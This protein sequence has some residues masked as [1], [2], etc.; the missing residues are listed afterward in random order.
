MPKPKPDYAYEFLSRTLAGTKP[1]AE[2]IELL[3]SER[4]PEDLHLDYKSGKEF[5]E[6]KTPATPGNPTTYRGKVQRFVAG[7]AN[8]DGGLL[9]IGVG[10]VKK[11]NAHTGKEEVHLHVDG[12][13]L[14]TERAVLLT[15]EAVI[16]LRPYL[17]SH[18]IIHPVDVGGE[19][20]LVVAVQRSDSLVICLEVNKSIVHYLRIHDSTPSAPGYLVEDIVLGR[21]RRP[22]FRVTH[23]G[24][25]AEQDSQ[26]KEWRTVNV[27]I[28]ATNEGLVWMHEPCAGIVTPMRTSGSVMISDRLLDHI[29]VIPPFPLTK[30][31]E[32]QHLPLTA[33][34][35]EA[36]SVGPFGK[37]G[38]SYRS[39]L[40]K[41]PTMGVESCWR[42]AV[43]VVCRDQPPSWHQLQIRWGAGQE[44]RTYTVAIDPVG[45]QPAVVGFQWM[46][47]GAWYPAF[48]V[49]PMDAPPFVPK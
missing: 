42:A 32:I 10:E 49:E 44:F 23:E 46:H 19:L 13:Q 21:R 18:P 41:V 17:S 4:V 31:P 9:V 33:G 22:Q 14:D 11:P 47:Q 8:S 45:D 15:K 20:V 40:I 30:L 48:P 26:A 34:V 1:T 28:F 2:D 27:E 36:G 7:F 39:S 16:G 35:G 3:V 29:Q 5:D 43:Y 24:T 38:F 12:V 6:E 37:R 25:T